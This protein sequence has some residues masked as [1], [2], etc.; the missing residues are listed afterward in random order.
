M[1]IYVDSDYKWYII[2]DDTITPVETNF[3]TNKCDTLES[4][5]ILGIKI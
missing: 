4:L 3:F 1:T 2:N 5:K